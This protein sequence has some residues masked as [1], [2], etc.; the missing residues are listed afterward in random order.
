MKLYDVKIFS[1]LPKQIT[2]EDG[3]VLTEHQ[4]GPKFHVK[5]EDGKDWQATVHINAN[6][7]SANVRPAV[8]IF[9]T[10]EQLTYFFE[11]IDIARRKLSEEA[12][13]E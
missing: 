10:K 11:S 2:Q 7:D 1:D 6:S 4:P 5:V 3:T 8:I 9:M 13:N 12:S